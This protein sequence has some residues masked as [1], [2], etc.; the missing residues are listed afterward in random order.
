MAFA[1]GCADPWAVVR[2]VVIRRASELHE[3]HPKKNGH[4]FGQESTA[5]V[6]AR[7]AGFAMFAG[8]AGAAVLGHPGGVGAAVAGAKIALGDEPAKKLKSHI[9]G[10]GGSAAAG[11]AGK[12]IAEADPFGLNS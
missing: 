9:T 7:S 11:E 8:G 5:D 3:Y 1:G 2:A 4:E 10:A 12:K 6:L